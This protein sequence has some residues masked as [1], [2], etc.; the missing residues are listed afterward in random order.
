[1]NLIKKIIVIGLSAVINIYSQSL[2]VGLSSGVSIV[3]GDNYYT[4]DFGYYG[5]YFY[6]VNDSKIQFEKIAMFDIIDEKAFSH[7]TVRNMEDLRQDIKDVLK[8]VNREVQ[9]SNK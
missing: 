9:K 1:M 6:L 7:R 8:A 5:T 2:S 4:R 3:Q